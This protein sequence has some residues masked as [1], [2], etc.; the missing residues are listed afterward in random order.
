M[1]TSHRY[2]KQNSKSTQGDTTLIPPRG[3]GMAQGNPPQTPPLESET[4]TKVVWPLPNHKRNFPCGILAET[5]CLIGDPQCVPFLFILNLLLFHGATM[6][7]RAVICYRTTTAAKNSYMLPARP[8]IQAPAI[9]ACY[10]LQPARGRPVH[11]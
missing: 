1:G 10:V 5:P 3:S 7:C 2:N 4:Y 11:K 8:P 9:H 6:R